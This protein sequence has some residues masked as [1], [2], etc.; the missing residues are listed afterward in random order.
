MHSSWNLPAVTTAKTKRNKLKQMKKLKGAI[1]IIL[2][3][4]AGSSVKA[5]LMP[6]FSQY[7]FNDY[8]LNPAIGGTHD[9]WQIKTNYSL[10]MAGMTDGPR[11]YLLSGYGPHKKLPMGYGGYI[12][13]DA[14]GPVSNLG[15]YGSYAYNLRITGDLRLSMGLFAGFVQQKIDMGADDFEYQ[16]DPVIAALE[17]NGTQFMP[18]ASVG[19]YAYTSQYFGGI[20]FNHLFFNKMN[21]YDTSTVDADRNAFHIYIQ[22]GYKYNLNRNFDIVPALLM[23]GVPRYDYMIDLNVRTIYQKMVWLGLGFRTSV[24]NAE[25]LILNVGYNYNDMVNIGYSYDITLSKL[26]TYSS[27]SH[28]IM[29]GVKFND[30]RRS[31][32]RRKIR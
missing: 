9:Y 30:I 16:D 7:M 17:K 29:L 4:F 8:P 14:N 13:N 18:D 21:L 3:L 27:G 22:G 24:K 1:V 32:S 25:S 15:V 10:R 23:K 20:S 5:Q 28:E 19:F 12:F 26:R 31:S 2:I 11:T 6:Q